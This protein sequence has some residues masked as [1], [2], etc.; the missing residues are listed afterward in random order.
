MK[1]FSVVMPFAGK[2][3][4]TVEADNAEDALE[5]FYQEME[6]IE[7]SLNKVDEIGGEFSWDFYKKM[8]EG[9][10]CYLDCINMKLK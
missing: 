4:L 1:N 8:I 3:Q 2:I 6:K 5:K 9:N 10:V 7:Y